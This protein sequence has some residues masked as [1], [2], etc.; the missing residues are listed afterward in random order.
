MG[1]T[2]QGLGGQ[3]ILPPANLKPAWTD[4]MPGALDSC[5][6]PPAGGLNTPNEFSNITA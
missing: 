1:E 2:H 4:P 3:F 5:A 6:L